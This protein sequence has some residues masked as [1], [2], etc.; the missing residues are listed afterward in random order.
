MPNLQPHASNYILGTMDLSLSQHHGD[1]VANHPRPTKADWER[2]KP[3]IKRK[4]IDERMELK[5]VKSDME[6]EGF[7]AT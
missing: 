1:N 4:Y 6:Q 5:D 2:A 3:V 7:Y